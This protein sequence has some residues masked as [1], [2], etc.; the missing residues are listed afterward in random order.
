MIRRVGRTE[1]QKRMRKKEIR[2]EGRLG[3]GMEE[4]KR[5]RGEYSIRYNN[6]NMYNIIIYN[7]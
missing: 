6:S 3:K 2:G 7:I 4:E 1:E 5:R